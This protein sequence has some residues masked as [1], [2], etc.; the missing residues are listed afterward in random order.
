MKT[1]VAILSG[2]A[3]GCIALAGCG[4]GDSAT[5]IYGQAPTT[6]VFVPTQLDTAS[7]LALAQKQSETSNPFPVDGGVVQVTPPDDQTND[8]LSINA[9]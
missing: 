8:P 3:L 7:V 4:G 9:I 6:P 1:K 2:T 5:D